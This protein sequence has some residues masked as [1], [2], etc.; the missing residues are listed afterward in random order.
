MSNSFGFGGTNGSLVFK[1]YS[2]ETRISRLY[3]MMLVNGECKEHI[4]ISDRGFNTV[5]DYLKR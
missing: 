5:M 3:L 2:R 4:E 1:R